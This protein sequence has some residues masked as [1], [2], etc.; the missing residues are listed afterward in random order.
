METAI[1]YA[2]S[3]GTTE[4]VAQKIK[5]EI[6]DDS[7]LFNLKTNPSIDLSQFDAVIIGGSIHAGNIQRKVKD[8]CS[9]NLVDLLQKKV[10]LFICG[11]NEPQLEVEFKNAYPELLRKHAVTT[12]CVGGEFLFEKMNF[13][14]RFIVRKISGVSQSVSKIDEAKVHE[15]VRE[16]NFDTVN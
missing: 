12:K 4:K 7:T 9:S 8:Y 1:I 2:T 13:F 10:G 5:M 6:G 15:I 14:E 3:H 16:M 11:M